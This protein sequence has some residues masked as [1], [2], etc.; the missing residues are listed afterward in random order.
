MLTT[1]RSWYVFSVPLPR[2][3]TRSRS[4]LQTNHEQSS[5]ASTGWLLSTPSYEYSFD[6][7]QSIGLRS[8]PTEPL[9]PSR[10]PSEPYFNLFT[11]PGASST[12]DLPV[13]F[14]SLPEMGECH[15][16]EQWWGPGGL[17]IAGYPSFFDPTPFQQ[18]SH[19]FPHN[20][21]EGHG[22]SQRRLST[23]DVLQSSGK[24]EALAYPTP[25]PS[26]PPTT[27]MLP[28]VPFSFSQ[29]APAKTEHYGLVH[30]PHPPH[31]TMLDISGDGARIIQ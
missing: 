23:G 3:T 21:A 14:N 15:E 25:P 29:V 1:P 4:H 7:A 5:A 18:P 17:G 30:Q 31:A 10:V 28:A 16:Y 26:S 19:Q 20:I 9:P 6:S 24:P 11:H 2:L 8:L 22:L 27:L 13:D 12:V